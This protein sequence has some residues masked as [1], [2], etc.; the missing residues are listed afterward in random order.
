MR[1][2]RTLTLGGLVVCGGCTASQVEEG[3][4][5]VLRGKAV[6]EAGAALSGELLKFYR[7]E[8]SA[9]ALA[10]FSSSWKTVKT[11]AD[12]T[13]KLELLGADTRNGSIAR[14]FVAHTPARTQGRGVSAAFLIQA[15]EV[16]MPT[17]QEWTGAPTAT[18]AAQGVSV[19]FKSLSGTHGAGPDAHTL[20]VRGTSLRPVWVISKA[21]APATLSDY[22]LEDMAGLKAFLTVER[23]AK[24]GEE[25][26]DI[27][28]TSD[29]VA[30]PRRALVPMSRGATCTYTNAVTPCP[31]TQGSL[32]DIVLF[33]SGVREV[34]LQ[35]PRAA[36][37]RKAVLRNFAV[38][39]ILSELVLEGSADGTQWTSMANLLPDVGSRPFMELDLTGTT[40]VSHVR[41]RAVARDTT[42]ELRSLGQL[43]LFE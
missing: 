40:P 25:T 37:L 29:E 22:A 21:T 18:A 5:I 41:I 11:E 36:V 38:S 43:S 30:L 17:L 39:G 16:T 14:C 10:S 34:A 31:L 19:G 42:G 26:V 7:S 15:G 3:Q 32:G 20:T 8:N 35:L 9:C 13:F 6:D 23:D 2:M 28:Y 33:Q 12:G 27:T 4:D 24:V 1:W